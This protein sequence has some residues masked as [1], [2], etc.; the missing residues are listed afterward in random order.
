MEITLETSLSRQTRLV[1]QGRAHLA[2]FAKQVKL[3]LGH[4]LFMRLKIINKA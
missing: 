3:T 1:I 2:Y 4:F